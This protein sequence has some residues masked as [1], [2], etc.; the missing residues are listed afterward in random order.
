MEESCRQVLKP[1]LLRGGDRAEEGRRDGSSGKG[2]K[3]ERGGIGR[4]GCRRNTRVA[5]SVSVTPTHTPT[6]PHTIEKAHEPQKCHL[7]M[8][9]DRTAHEK[10]LNCQTLT[11]KIRHSN[12]F[13]AGGQKTTL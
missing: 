5:V 9:R 7:R 11:F 12:Y 3:G 4:V 13:G 1:H 10:M 2:E 8:C 6:P